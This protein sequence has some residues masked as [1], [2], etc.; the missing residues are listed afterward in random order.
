MSWDSDIGV[1]AWQPGDALP[2]HNDGCMICGTTSASSPLVAPFRVLADDAVGTDVRFDDRHQGAPL[3]AHGGMVAAVLDDACGYVSFV[4]L[5]IFVTA[6]LEVDYRRPVLLGHVYAVRAW[7]EQVDGRKVHLRA[8]L[9]DLADGTVV[10]EAKGLFVT[11]DLE[12][13]RP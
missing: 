2:A 4:V 6:H 9:R 11:V 12:H 1:G 13:F 5:R 7:C 3:Y 8:E 10:A